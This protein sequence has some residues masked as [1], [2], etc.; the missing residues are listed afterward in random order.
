MSSSLQPSSQSL[1]T[2]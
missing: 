2:W 1:S